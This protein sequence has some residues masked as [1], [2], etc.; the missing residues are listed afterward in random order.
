MTEGASHERR[1]LLIV[2]GVIVFGVIASIA[3]VSQTKK[4]EIAGKRAFPQH[5]VYQDIHR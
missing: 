1:S 5:T 2:M 3:W 4:K